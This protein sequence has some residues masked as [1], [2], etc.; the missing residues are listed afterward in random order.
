MIYE[1]WYQPSPPPSPHTRKNNPIF[2]RHIWINE[3]KT[4]V[5]MVTLDAAHSR[6][7]LQMGDV[8]SLVESLA[9]KNSRI[10]TAAPTVFQHRRRRQ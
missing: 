1:N 8:R 9:G 2:T 3:A 4:I 10:N 5:H 7:S 6:R